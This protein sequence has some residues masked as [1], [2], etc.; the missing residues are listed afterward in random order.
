MNRAST[1]PLCPLTFDPRRTGS[2]IREQESPVKSHWYCALTGAGLLL[3]AGAFAQER[4]VGAQDPDALFHS[5]DPRLNANKQIV[6]HIFKDILEGGNIEVIDKYLS[7][8]YIQHNPNIPSGHDGLKKMLS[9]VK[10]R[11]VSQKLAAQV[12]SVV[13]E[14]DFVVV[15]AVQQLPDPRS[16][17]KTYTTTHFD[18]WRI[19]DGQA[20]EHWDE[21]ALG[22]PPA[23]TPSAP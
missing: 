6:Y 20:D 11:P 5:S 10:P 1:A 4:V 14:G 15:S 9:M 22:P 3:S 18:M 21:A 13:A 16:P 2:G 17:G 7:E 23:L 19:K 8:R 12:V